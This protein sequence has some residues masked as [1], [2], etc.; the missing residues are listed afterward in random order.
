MES[1]DPNRET[2]RASTAKT[3]RPGAK[4]GL[5]AG[6]YA[7]A[8]AAAWLIVSIYQAATRG[9]DRQNYG[10]MFACGDSILFLA[11]FGVAAV[12]ATAAA[13]FFLKPRAAFWRV[14]AVAS[15]A[16]AATA[17]AGL[18][19]HFAPGG[20]DSSSF[21]RTWSAFGTL[22]IFVAPL[23]AIFFLLAGLIAPIRGSRISLLVAAMVEAAVF[24]CVAVTWLPALRR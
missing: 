14:L 1:D 10:M 11:V 7:P 15:L 12:P 3:L 20:F 19:G 5:V 4:A 9:A 13:L 24:V 22:R 23:F 2:P 6:G 17:V 8:L 18:M 16:V 21:L